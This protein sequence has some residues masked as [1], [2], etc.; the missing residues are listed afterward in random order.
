MS[1]C[2]FARAQVW[3]W[4]EVNPEQMV[5]GSGDGEGAAGDYYYGSAGAVVANKTDPNAETDGRYSSL[6]DLYTE[7][8]NVA[9]R[10]GYQAAAAASAANDS[11]APAGATTLD[12]S[13]WGAGHVVLAIGPERGWTDTELEL[14]ES[15][16]FVGVGM[17][18]RSLSSSV[19]VLSATSICQEALR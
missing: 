14:L 18:P 17:G 4:S 15:E 11:G 7:A 19:A 12:A 2:K 16:G 9:D 3:N 1:C 13:R 5:E 10:E 6:V 8:F